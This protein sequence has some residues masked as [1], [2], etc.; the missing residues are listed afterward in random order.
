VIIYR[1]I[2][3]ISTRLSFARFSLSVLNIN[4][5]SVD[6]R[7]RIHRLRRPHRKQCDSITKISLFCFSIS[8]QMLPWQFLECSFLNHWKEQKKVCFAK[9]KKGY[10]CPHAIGYLDCDLVW[11]FPHAKLFKYRLLSFVACCHTDRFIIRLNI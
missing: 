11:S 6:W 4:L 9:L 3:Y 2:I 7:L 8:W 5:S 1:L 10:L